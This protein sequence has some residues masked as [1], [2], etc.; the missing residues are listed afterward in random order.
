MA[1]AFAVETLR[2]R[3]EVAEEEVRRGIFFFLCS[4]LPHDRVLA[5]NNPK[6]LTHQAPVTDA[7]SRFVDA[8]PPPQAADGRRGIP[9]PDP[10]PGGGEYFSAWGGRGAAGVGG[11]PPPADPY[12]GEAPSSSY[13]AYGSAEYGGGGGPGDGF[14]SGGG[15]DDGGGPS[16]FYEWPAAGYDGAG[17]APGDE[18]GGDGG[19]GGY[20]SGG[21]DAWRPT[22]GVGGARRGSGGSGGGGPRGDD[23]E[24]WD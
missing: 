24:D 22:A 5:L 11:P 6:P 23:V 1:L 8:P 20:A 17:Y 15:V 21:E 13:G 10:G 4:F 18:V 19:G 12:Y 2:L 14:Y 9:L 3:E 16:T 7:R